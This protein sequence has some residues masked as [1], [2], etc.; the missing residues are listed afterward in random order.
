LGDVI[1]RV[2]FEEGE[3]GEHGFAD[4]GEVA[5]FSIRLHRASINED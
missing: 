1:N 5:Q 2:D 4:A 3:I